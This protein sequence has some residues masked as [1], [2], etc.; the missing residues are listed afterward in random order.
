MP[1]WNKGKISSTESQY[2]VLTASMNKIKVYCIRV[3]FNG[4]KLM[5]Q[6]IFEGHKLYSLDFFFKL[7]IGFISKVEFFGEISKSWCKS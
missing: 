2:S 4:V 6:T 1:R 3:R 5:V 7:R